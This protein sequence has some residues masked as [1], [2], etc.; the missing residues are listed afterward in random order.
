MVRLSET[1]RYEFATSIIIKAGELASSYFSDLSKLV[2]EKKGHQ[3]LVSEADKNVEIFIRDQISAMFPNDNIIGE[4]G[5]ASP[6]T[7]AT[8]SSYIWVIDPIDG[9]ANFVSGIP[10]WTVVIA[11]VKD[12]VV[13]AGFIFDPLQNE[14]FTA[15][16]GE[17]AFCNGVRLAVSN[18]QSLHDGSVAVGFSNRSKAGFINKLVTQIVDDGGVFFRNASGAMSLAY[19]AAGRLIGY[20]EDHMN[21]WDYL[22]GQLMVKEAGVAIEEQNIT[23]V[24]QQGGRVIASNKPIFA[25]LKKMTEIALK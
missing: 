5:G 12:D 3:D 23:S 8:N 18:A 19:V 6:G 16:A 20:S 22:A 7:G 17:G 11:L 25:S 10:A 14:L 2:I 1:Q 24:L 21:A 13:I 15:T 9:T 4:E